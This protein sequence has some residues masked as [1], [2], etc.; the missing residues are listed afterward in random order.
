VLVVP[1]GGANLASLSDA[2]ARLGADCEISAAPDAYARAERIVLPGVGAAPEA[3]LRLEAA[4]LVERLR[5]ERRPVLGICLGMQLLFEASAEGETL[6]LGV[7][8]G[9]VERLR[10]GPGVA[11]PHMGWS[12][13]APSRPSRLLGDGG[14][15]FYFVHSYAGA[16][17]VDTVAVAEHGTTFAAV[18]ER[19]PFF[20]VQFH[21]ERSSEAGAALLARFLDLPPCA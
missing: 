19:P 8:S 1:T 15:W 7:L 10:G 5:R 18:V 21:P 11:V 17:Q 12:R 9:R 6:G 2:F 20:G 3:R 16:P 4:G 13:V 14:G